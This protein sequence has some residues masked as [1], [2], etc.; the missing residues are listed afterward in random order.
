MIKR[1]SWKMQRK[2]MTTITLWA[3]WKCRCN[4]RYDAIYQ[5]LSD[6]LREI[7][8]NLVAVVR[9]QYDN[10]QGSPETVNKRKK[11]LLHIWKKL[12]LFSESTQGSQWNYQ[13]PWTLSWLT[14]KH[15]KLQQYF[16]F[17]TF[18]KV[19]SLVLGFSYIIVHENCKLLET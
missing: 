10:M 17:F 7:W 11:K 5:C 19:L 18:Y 8:E 12:P 3:L 15:G 16:L 2:T 14:V 9:G 13:L 1:I 6:V 4:W